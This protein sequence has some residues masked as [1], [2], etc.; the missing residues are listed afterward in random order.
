QLLAGI[1]RP[2]GSNF[3]CDCDRCRRYRSQHAAR[4]HQIAHRKIAA[5][6]DR[7]ATN[8]SEPTSPDDLREP[9]AASLSAA[10]TTSR[11]GSQHGG[12]LT[13]YKRQTNDP[14]R[15]LRPYAARQ[16]GWKA[17]KI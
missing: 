13:R 11:T 15:T 7:L 2:V 10:S 8:V 9:E 3:R 16:R 6:H 17:S 14:L 5:S 12:Q 1:D 4:E